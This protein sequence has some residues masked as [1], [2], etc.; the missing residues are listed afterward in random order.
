MGFQQHWCS[1]KSKRAFS[2]S[3]NFNVLDISSVAQY[4]CHFNAAGA[5]VHYTFDGVHLL[6]HG[7]HSFVG[8]A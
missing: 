2:S 6:L 4:S 7:V 8:R 3:C 5:Q 1:T